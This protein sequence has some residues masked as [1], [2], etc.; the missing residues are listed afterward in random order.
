M[1]SRLGVTVANR[2]EIIHVHFLLHSLMTSN[3]CWGFTAPCGFFP[4][5]FFPMGDHMILEFTH[6]IFRTIFSV[7]LQAH[8]DVTISHF[9]T[10]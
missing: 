7:E 8:E 6:K 10:V 3:I 5:G 2:P 9:Q 1:K 4:M